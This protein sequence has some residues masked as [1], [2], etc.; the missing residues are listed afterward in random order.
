MPTYVYRCENCND[1]EIDHKITEPALTECP[2]CGGK[3]ERQVSAP[4]FHLKGSG[5]FKSDYR[6]EI[7]KQEKKN[8]S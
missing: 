4:A 7:K 5:W 8:D 6:T 3:V 1:M 2:E